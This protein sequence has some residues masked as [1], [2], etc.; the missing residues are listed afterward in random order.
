MKAKVLYYSRTGNTKKIAE[1]IAQALNEKAGSE[2]D[3][4]ASG[5]N[6]M[7]RRRKG[8]AQPDKGPILSKRFSALDESFHTTDRRN[9]KI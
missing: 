3:G 1:A 5:V 2:L 8:V 6:E 9:C 4:R 7:G